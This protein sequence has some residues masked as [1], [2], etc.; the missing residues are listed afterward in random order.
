[1]KV[2]PISLKCQRYTSHQTHQQIFIEISIISDF[3]NSVC[4]GP[5]NFLVNLHS[6][7]SGEKGLLITLFCQALVDVKMGL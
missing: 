2:I 1:M 6:L 7:F 5:R 3:F 4:V